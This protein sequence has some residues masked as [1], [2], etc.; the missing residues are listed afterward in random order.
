MLGRVRSKSGGPGAEEELVY[1]PIWKLT[2]VIED[3]IH[4]SKK[5]IA[6]FR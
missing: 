5:F 2:E 1:Y 4:S 3:E 6:K